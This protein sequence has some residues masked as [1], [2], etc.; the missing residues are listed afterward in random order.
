MVNIVICQIK[1]DIIMTIHAAVVAQPIQPSIR[2]NLFNTISFSSCYINNCLRLCYNN[3]LRKSLLKKGNNSICFLKFALL[4]PFIGE[5]YCK[6]IFSIVYTCSD[7]NGP[8]G[9]KLLHQAFKKGLLPIKLLVL[10]FLT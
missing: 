4:S 3:N 5:N 2:Q 10:F 9:P 1:A 7:D 6:D 8:P